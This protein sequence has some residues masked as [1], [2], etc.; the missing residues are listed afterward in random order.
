M[1]QEPIIGGYVINPKTDRIY[2]IILHNGNHYGVG[3]LRDDN[4]EQRGAI[5]IFDSHMCLRNMRSYGYLNDVSFNDIKAYKDGFL[6]CGC[7]K[8]K[9]G[10]EYNAFVGRFTSKLDHIE[11]HEYC[12][13]RYNHFTDISVHVTKR[14][15][16]GKVHNDSDIIVCAGESYSNGVVCEISATYDKHFN[17]LS[18]SRRPIYG[19]DYE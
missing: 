14:I 5:F 13:G 19:D 18:R 15:I 16:H 9:H 4:D 11:S 7:T 2:K 8:A 10:G 12:N 6:V 3:F 17:L 1:R